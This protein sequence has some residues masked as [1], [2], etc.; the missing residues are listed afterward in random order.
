MSLTRASRTMPA[1]LAKLCLENKH[2]ALLAKFREIDHDLG[3]NRLHS[4]PA[5]GSY[6]VPPTPRELSLKAKLSRSGVL[7]R[8]LKFKFEAC[9]A[10]NR[11]HTDAQ[12]ELDKLKRMCE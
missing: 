11:S 10:C 4:I 3:A 7:C 2:K 1:L 5:S 8:H 6:F 9:S 12:R